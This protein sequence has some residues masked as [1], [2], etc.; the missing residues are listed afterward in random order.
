MALTINLGLTADATGTANAITATY[1]PA[2]T[3]VDKKI[4]FLVSVSPNTSTAPTFSPNGLTARPIVKN[5]GALLSS[6]D[7]VGLGHVVIL[8]YNLANTRWELLNPRGSSSGSGISGLTTNELVYGNSATTIASLPVATYP[9]LTELSYVKGLPSAI[10]PYIQNGTDK[11]AVA[12]GT[13]TYLAT[14]SPVPTAY[15][16]G[17]SFWIKIP[18]TNTT[19]PTL[20][21]N[22]LGAKTIKGANGVA[23]PVGFFT[24]GGNYDFVYDGTD[25][26][27][28]AGLM[29]RKD[30]SYYKKTGATTYE[31]WY[32]Y[33]TTNLA[34]T[35]GAFA[36][37]LL[38]A[39]PFVVSKTIT[40]DRIGMEITVAGTAA[41]V[42]RMG[43]YADLNNVPNALVLDAGTI[44]GDSATVQ[45][46]TINQTLT[47]GLYWLT[48]IHNST[49]SITFRIFAIGATPSVLGI[50]S[51]F[52]ATPI[53]IGVQ[54]TLVYTTLP[55][56]FTATPTVLT[57]AQPIIAVR[58]SS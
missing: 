52:G 20:N 47:P 16:T 12:T 49:A 18:N 43:I 19:T 37:D 34:V 39:M 30:V 38:R 33:N 44:A 7:I 23:L 6:G 57:A 22:S 27:C 4:L 41:S 14:L 8:E 51:A 56:T 10:S 24:A 9:S 42:V 3:L 53:G 46:I 29:D 1:S 55:N 2:P 25:F 45:S 36:K 50:D 58:L 28:Q 31:R 5:G 32:S 17:Q 13:D 48:Y 11:Y 35:T 26:I 15:A 54:S 40:I 21:I